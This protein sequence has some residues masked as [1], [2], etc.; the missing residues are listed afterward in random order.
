MAEIEN[1]IRSNSLYKYEI[2]GTIAAIITINSHG[3]QEYDEIPWS[4]T[5]NN[6]LVVHRLAVLPIYQDKGIA[7]KMMGFCE[8]FAQKNR[9]TSI[10]L[11]AFVKNPTACNLYRR[12]E[13]IEKGTVRFRKGAFF[14]FEKMLR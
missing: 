2:N 9:N 12:L 14:C 3:S 6:F 13:Y 10:R 5:T 7:K 8:E 4:D 11:D 1:D